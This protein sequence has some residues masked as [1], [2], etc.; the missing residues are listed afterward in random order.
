MTSYDW[1]NTV[2]VRVN[3]VLETVIKYIVHLFTKLCCMCD[4]QKMER[5]IKY[6]LFIRESSGQGILL[7]LSSV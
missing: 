5:H 1:G 6:K 4:W 3:N 7:I 2:F